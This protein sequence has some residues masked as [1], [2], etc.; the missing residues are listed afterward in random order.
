MIPMQNIYD[1]EEFLNSYLEMRD[2]Q[3]G[4]NESLEIPAFRSLLPELE[5]KKVLDLGCGYGENCQWY[6]ESGAHQVVGVDISEKMIEKARREF[7]GDRIDYINSPMEK[8][9]FAEGSFDLVVSSLSFHYVK[10]FTRLIEKI[11]SFLTTDGILIFSQQH[12]IATAK[13]TK[14]GWCKNKAGEKLHWIM[15]DYQFEGKRKQEWFIDGVVKYH[16][17]IST[18]LNTLI[19]QGFSILKVL[20]PTPIEEAEQ[21]REELKQEKRRPPFIMLKA[22]NN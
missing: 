4:L 18:L 6:A 21:D 1:N 11:S 16:R 13:Q 20:E 7:S 9:E 8:V 14:N 5:N 2:K 12:P 17:T 19:E 15:D 3:E 10:N 22:K